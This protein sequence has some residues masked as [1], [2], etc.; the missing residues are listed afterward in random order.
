MKR[1]LVVD[2]EPF[3]VRILKLNLQREGYDVTTALDGEEALQAIA[4]SQPDAII[5]D[6]QM[7][8]MDGISLC[9]NIRKTLSDKKV[10]IVLTTSRTEREYR[11]LAA[12]LGGIKFMEKPISLRALT[13]MFKD[14]FS[15]SVAIEEGIID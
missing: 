7:P 1:V 2:D 12:D 3:N 13:A 8:R 14:Y 9:Q 4:L 11:E 15:S 10:L 5:T 6:I